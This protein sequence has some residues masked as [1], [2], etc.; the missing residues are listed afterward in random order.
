MNIYEATRLAALTHM[1]IT[2]RFDGQV[3]F[4][5]TPTNDARL[6][7]ISNPVGSNPTRGWQPCLDDLLSEEWEVV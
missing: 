1:S 7:A 2:Q 6:C 4:K 5:I 3:V